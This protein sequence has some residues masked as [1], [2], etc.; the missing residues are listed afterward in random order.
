MKHI[1]HIHSNSCYLSALLIID[2]EGLSIQDCIL[3][4]CRNVKVN[5]EKFK[6]IEIEDEIYS[7]RYNAIRY[8]HKFPFKKN[9]T[10]IDKIDASIEE[11]IK[12]DQY[13]YYAPHCR[14][15]FYQVFITHPRCV[16]VHYLEDGMDAYLD[17]ES[18][19]NRFPPYKPLTYKVY[20][21]VLSFFDEYTKV[22]RTS[23]Y[24]NLY[25][26]IGRYPSI[27]YG[28]SN[29]SFSHSEKRKCLVFS[30][31]VAKSCI[32]TA[33]VSDSLL[34]LDAVVEQ[35]VISED[36]FKRFIEWFFS[37]TI[38]GPAINVKFHPMQSAFSKRYVLEAA[39]KN[40]INCNI[41][42]EN[43]IEIDL[44]KYQGLKIY[45]IGSSLLNFASLT[46]RHE[47]H[48]L[49]DFFEQKLGYLSP[50]L[51]LWKKAFS[52]NERVI[53]FGN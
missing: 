5:K 31:A 45:G 48:A 1:F 47:V 7:H 38:S 36:A 27:L 11:C 40:D 9:K 34:L 4:I 23:R 43:L 19:Y 35:N 16:Q 13:T 33:Y 32:G 24:V 37:E 2:N 49:Y 17:M 18:I 39:S 10:Y 51:E 50:R 29:Q 8:F 12:Q 20:D 22:S 26:D 41:L 52:S 25:E 6:T 53:K 30:D 15:P 44:Y 42:D 46:N 3:F 28:L 21:K 14:N